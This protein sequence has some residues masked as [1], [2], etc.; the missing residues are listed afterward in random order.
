MTNQK[1]LRKIATVALGLFASAGMAAVLAGC[2][3]VEGAGK[4]VERGGQKI[5]RAAERNK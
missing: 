5:E 4:D 3:T 2:N 1:S